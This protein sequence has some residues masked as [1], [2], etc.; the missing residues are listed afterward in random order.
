MTPRFEKRSD[1]RLAWY[2]DTCGGFIHGGNGYLRVSKELALRRKRKREEVPV[3]GK[4]T[5][6][7]DTWSRR[8]PW[9]AL[10]SGCDNHWGDWEGDYTIGV[11][12]LNLLAEAALLMGKPWVLETDW[13]DLLQAVSDA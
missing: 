5:E 6:N 2:C 7:W 9:R 3:N 10:C 8:I 1:G 4:Y 11:Y 12:P 13:A